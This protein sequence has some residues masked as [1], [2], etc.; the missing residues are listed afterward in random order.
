MVY[1]QSTS[2]IF[3]VR[4][5]FACIEEVN[6]NQADDF[7]SNVLL[8]SVHFFSHFLGSQE[9]WIHLQIQSCTVC[10]AIT[11]LAIYLETNSWSLLALVQL[12]ALLADSLVEAQE[13]SSALGQDNVSFYCCWVY[14]S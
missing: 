14:K 1:F 9:G 12:L 7:V 10:P 8:N 11:C 5:Y 4:V 3:G 6:N 2:F 13:Q